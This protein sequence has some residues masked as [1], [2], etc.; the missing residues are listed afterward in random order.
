[1]HLLM[2]MSV[3]VWGMANG[4]SIISYFYFILLK[5]NQVDCFEEKWNELLKHTSLLNCPVL[6]I[7]LGVSGTYYQVTASY[8][9]YDGFDKLFS[10]NIITVL[11][12]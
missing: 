8:C 7:A 1:M 12:I 3:A 9:I 5:C 10:N 11:V 2:L 6:G 4:K